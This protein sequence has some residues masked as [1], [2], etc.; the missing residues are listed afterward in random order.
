MDSCTLRDLQ[1]CIL[2]EFCHAVPVELRGKF[3]TRRS[4][5]FPEL[6]TLQ[7]KCA[8]VH[9]FVNCIHLK[10]S[11]AVYDRRCFIIAK[12]NAGHAASSCFKGNFWEP[13]KNRSEEHTSELQ[14]HSFI[15]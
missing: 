7:A 5:A 10:A 3:S 1:V 15:F 6:R 9:H 14:Y 13:F 12:N 11:K 8:L 4:H 2:P